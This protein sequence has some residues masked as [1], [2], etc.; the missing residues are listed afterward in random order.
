MAQN[1]Y[2]I[3]RGRYRRYFDR[4]GSLFSFPLLRIW[5][6]KIDL[7]LNFFL[8]MFH[9][10]ELWSGLEIETQ[11]LSYLW[12][13]KSKG[14]ELHFNSKK[15]WKNYLKF[16][17]KFKIYE[18]LKAQT[19]IFLKF[20]KFI[21][22]TANPRIYYNFFNIFKVKFQIFKYFEIIFQTFISVLKSVFPLTPTHIKIYSL[23]NA[24]TQKF[25]NKPHNL[26][27]KSLFNFFLH[28]SEKFCSTSCKSSYKVK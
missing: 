8:F 10:V 16:K 6:E 12:G 7:R 14:W 22:K 27:L 1:L 9:F 4:M 15:N 26:T 20:C 13:R 24:S 5:E 18:A 17:I 25:P 2:K 28:L 21:F 23:L 11:L 19:E 3:L